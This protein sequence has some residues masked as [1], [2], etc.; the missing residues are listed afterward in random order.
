MGVLLIKDVLKSIMMVLGELSVMMDGIETMQMLPAGSW[1]IQ[2]VF[3]SAVVIV[4][5]KVVEQ[6]GWRQSSV[7]ER[8]RTFKAVLSARVVGVPTLALINMMSG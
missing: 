8:R 6:C 2:G 3:L 1:G 7:R 4:S 5:N